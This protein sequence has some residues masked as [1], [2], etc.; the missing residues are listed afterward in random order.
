MLVITNQIVYGP[1]R[2]VPAGSEI[3]LPDR[4]AHQLVNENKAAYKY[5]PFGRPP[6]EEARL[7]AIET[8]ALGSGV[9]NAM[10]PNSPRP[11]PQ[12]KS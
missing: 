7:K 12:G 3:D 5:P 10:K 1:G 4:E 9:M 8:A 11:K 6:E 2:F